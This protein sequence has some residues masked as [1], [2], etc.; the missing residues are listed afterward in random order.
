MRKMLLSFRADVFERVVNGTKIY[1]HRKVFPNEPVMAYLYV[2][3]PIQ[4]ITGIMWLDN[5]TKISTWIK[6]YQ[7]DPDAVTRI[8]EYLKNHTY[9]MEIQRFQPTN[10]ISLQQLRKDV[11]NFVVPQMYYYIEETE[12]LNYLEDNIVETGVAI[13]H[14]FSNITSSMICTH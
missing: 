14:D 5:K 4:A 6:K 3:K 10:S 2:S 11:A 9:A 12:L 1:E 13:E 8:T 7:D